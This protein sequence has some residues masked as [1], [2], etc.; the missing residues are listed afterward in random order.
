EEFI[1]IRPVL[2]ADL[3]DVPRATV[4]SWARNDRVTA[5][6]RNRLGEDTYRGSE[7]IELAEKYQPKRFAPRPKRRCA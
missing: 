3:P 6:G 7:L 5:H 2:F 1:L 4:L